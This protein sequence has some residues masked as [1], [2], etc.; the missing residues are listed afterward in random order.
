MIILSFKR[1]TTQEECKSFMK[2]YWVP[3]EYEFNT[4]TQEYEVALRPFNKMED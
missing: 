1:G 3:Q 2:H 4:D